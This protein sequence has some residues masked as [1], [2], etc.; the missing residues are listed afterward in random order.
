[1]SSLYWRYWK[2]RMGKGQYKLVWETKNKGDTFYG[3]F[4]NKFG[5]ETAK[6]GTVDLV[7]FHK[8]DIV[9][10][11]VMNKKYCELERK[12]EST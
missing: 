10:E 6:K 12:G 11:M 9:C 4:V 7:I 1:M 2:V 8:D 3:R 5:D